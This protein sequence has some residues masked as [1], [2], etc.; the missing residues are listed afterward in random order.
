MATNQDANHINKQLHQK[1]KTTFIYVTHDQTEAMTMG[2]RI[3]VMKDGFIQQVDSPVA[4]YKEPANLFVATFLG[5]PQMN[6]LNAKLSFDKNTL[7]AT[8]IDSEAK[9]VLKFS[10]TKTKQLVNKTYADKEVKFGIRP[11]AITIDP[12]GQIEA[13]IDVIEQLGDETIYYCTIPGINENVLIKAPFRVGLKPKEKIKISFDMENTYL[14]DKDTEKSILGMRTYN[15]F[16]TKISGNN[17][18]LGDNKI[19]IP[20]YLKNRILPSYEGKDL[21]LMSN[22]ASISL[23]PIENSIEI[24]I[25][26]EFSEVRGDYLATYFR[27]KGL[28]EYFVMKSKLDEEIKVNKIYLPTKD[29]KILDQNNEIINSVEE[30]RPN[31]TTGLLLRK[32]NELYVKAFGTTLKVENKPEYAELEGHVKVTIPF[33]G[34][35]CILK[36]KL[37]KANKIENVNYPQDNLITFEAYDELKSKNKNFIYGKVKGLSDYATFYVENNFSVYAMD[38]F[39][40]H[41]P[42]ELIKL[43]KAN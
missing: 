40:I 3:V 11:E 12:N 2:T 43:E 23:T 19:S 15:S 13:I 25:N 39:K 35:T 9:I 16:R 20:K 24:P 36:K 27:V 38:K 8:L 5:S 41:I 31:I 42:A 30:L 7:N 22:V 17:F 14:F 21:I 18:V 33:E 1:L 37:I 10:E 28:E 4:L 32:N 26:V 34:T 6:I 29:I